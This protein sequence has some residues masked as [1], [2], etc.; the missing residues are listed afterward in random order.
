[1][2]VDYSMMFQL[3]S[4]KRSPV[5]SSLSSAAEQFVPSWCDRAQPIS[6]GSSMHL[7]ARDDSTAMEHLDHSLPLGDPV[8]FGNTSVP[9]DLINLA[10]LATGETRS[11]SPSVGDDDSDEED[12]VICVRNTFIDIDSGEDGG[13]DA[14]EM[15]KSGAQTWT[16]SPLILR[17]HCQPQ[18]PSTVASHEGCRTP[19]ACESP[20]S[21]SEDVEA[22]FL[23]KT[24]SGSLSLAAFC[25]L[26][27]YHG[28]ATESTQRH[29]SPAA[30]PHLPSDAVTVAAPELS[31]T[32]VLLQVPLQLDCG[33]GT[34]FLNGSVDTSVEVLNQGQDP[35]TGSVS[36]QLRVLLRPHDWGTG[37]PLPAPLPQ[38]LQQPLKPDAMRKRSSPG[39]AA[40][41]KQEVICCHWKKGWCKLGESC[42]FE[43]T[44]ETCGVDT[45]AS[46]VADAC[47][48][49]AA[50]TAHP[51]KSTVAEPTPS[52]R[53]RSRQAVRHKH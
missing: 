25:G 17:N 24:P 19:P 48:G 35:V 29:S 23:L 37:L 21:T 1:V 33:P 32:M 27:E 49:A 45:S 38:Q 46:L 40:K 28:L 47:G 26:H 10:E 9:Q 8:N 16:V 13:L 7:A 18:Q 3:P 6:S 44:A 11:P 31:P 36:L 5:A 15:H 34:P 39:A 41:Q 20:E 12:T 50:V 2:S 22:P 42:K 53:R 14:V 51:L 43:H 4:G 52:R 30:R